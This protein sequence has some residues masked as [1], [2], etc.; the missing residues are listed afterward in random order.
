MSAEVVEL[1]SISE[2]VNACIARVQGQAV[3]SL[4]QDLYIP[5]NALEVILEIFEGPLDLLLYLIKK[6]NL[7]ILN[8]PVA[9]ITKQ[10]IAYV[11]LMTEFQLELAADYLEMAALL[12]EIKSRMLLPK[13]PSEEGEEVDPRAE[14]VRR[15]QEYERFKIAAQNLDE[16]PRLERDLFAV[17]VE[18]PELEIIKTH[19]EVDL[20]EILLALKEVLMRADLLSV[21]TVKKELL[22][23]RERMTKVLELLVSDTFVGFETFF[24]PTEGRLGVVVTFLAILELMKESVV[25]LVQNE[26]FGPIYLRAA[27]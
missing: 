21:H 4:P 11:D 5:P 10:Y 20:K 14:L 1:E 27:A 8:I 18:K 3:T 23:V 13:P 15:L 6:H 24:D 7:D 22:S 17:E 25:E 19:P 26:S 2:Q 16:Q 9:E 12:A